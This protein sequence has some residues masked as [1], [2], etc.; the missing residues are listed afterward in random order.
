MIQTQR[1]SVKSSVRTQSTIR[2]MC[3]KWNN[4]ARVRTPAA[5]LLQ[6][7][8]TLYCTK[9]TFA[10][11]WAVQERMK[12][13]CM[14]CEKR[15]FERFKVHTDE[16]QHGSQMTRECASEPSAERNYNWDSCYPKCVF[17]M[18]HRE[19]EIAMNWKDNHMLGGQYW[20]LPSPKR[21]RPCSQVL[22][23]VLMR[24]ENVLNCD[25]PNSTHHG[26]VHS[27][28]HRI[29]TV[30][31]ILCSSENTNIETPLFPQNAFHFHQWKKITIRLRCH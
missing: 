15:A 25:N 1:K 12:H 4:T 31:F 22:S 5:I 16:I 13:V 17:K 21:D 10:L 24:R 14:T 3:W 28:V 11:L 6:I 20:R 8:S 29:K 27:I 9:N 19:Q 23:N 2:I 18:P 7:F 26:H 30:V